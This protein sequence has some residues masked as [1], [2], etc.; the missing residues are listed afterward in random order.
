MAETT[1]TRLGLHRWSAN[2]D[3]V[4]RTEF[5]SSLA[6]LEALSAIFLEG[7]RA[8]RPAP[9]VTGRFYKVKGDT[10]LLNGMVFYDDGVAWTVVGS[11]V[12]D[13][14]VRA[15]A[16]GTI[17]L[18][19][20]GAAGQ[21]A[22]LQ[23]WRSSADAVLASIDPTGKGTLAALAV[24]GNATIGGTLGVTGATTLAALSVTT[25]QTSG[26]VTAFRIRSSATRADGAYKTEL[27]QDGTGRFD[28]LIPPATLL[29]RAST[30][31]P[32][33][34]LL[35]NGQAVSRATY[36]DLFAEI[37]TLYGVGDGST[38]FNL[39]DYRDKV[40]IGA[41]G[42]FAVGASGGSAT[43]VIAAANLPPHAHTINHQHASTTTVNGGQHDHPTKTNNVDGSS[44]VYLRTANNNG[45]AADSSHVIPAG[46][47]A[48]WF[49]PP[50]FYGDSGPGPGGSNPLDV[51]Q[52]YVVANVLIKV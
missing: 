41:G 8:A 27:K 52:P 43:K 24:V 38:T 36:A 37:G 31:I 4:D 33:G 23:E 30:N 1:T 13:A 6:Q 51:M 20:K 12:E 2:T 7:T 29:A 28:G 26:D 49:Q 46:D 5:E 21:T 48:H 16:V 34:W 9:G 14:I 47:H 3:T 15:S 40:I 10:A 45:A 44:T 42:A 22:N 11:N 19:A 35:C 32:A 25:L 18:V 17:P 39:P 50:A